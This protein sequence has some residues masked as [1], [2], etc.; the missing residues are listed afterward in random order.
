MKLVSK[1]VISLVLSLVLLLLFEQ[2]AAFGIKHNRNF[3]T[4]YIR[5]APINA[6]ILIQGPCQSEWMIDPV[7]LENLTQL[8]AYNLSLAHS[9]FADNYVFLLE[10]LKH[11]KKPKAVLLYVTPDSFDST[12]GNILNSYRFS[13]LARQKEVTNTIRDFDQKYAVASR[14]PF[15]NYSYYSNFTYYPVLSGWVDALNGNK[16]SRWPTGYVAPIYSWD[17]PE[18]FKELT[19]ASGKFFWSASI[20]KYFIKIIELMKRE[21]IAL[22]LYESP[23]YHPSVSKQLNRQEHLKKIDSI[24]AVYHV[25]FFRFDSLSMK[26]DPK[27]YFSTYNTT[28]KGNEIFNQFLGQFLKDTLPEIIRSKNKLPLQATK[29]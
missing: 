18:N 16:I 15:L 3:K 8:K 21:N 11:Q 12:R 9:N 26:Y 22:V 5:S 29:F 10:Y 17:R 25:P 24:S 4:S 20:E 27:N 2:L 28:I 14:V 6:D 13:F 1:I 7:I 19:P 23:L